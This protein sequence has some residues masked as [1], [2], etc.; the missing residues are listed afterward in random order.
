MKQGDVPTHFWSENM[1]AR[2]SWEDLDLNGRI[3]LERILGKEGGKL[4]AEFFWLWQGPVAGFCE[5]D[6]EPTVSIKGGEFLD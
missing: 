2:E 3:I 6:N 4:W 1:K 5:H